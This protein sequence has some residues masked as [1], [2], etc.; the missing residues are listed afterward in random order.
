MIPWNFSKFEEIVSYDRELLKFFGKIP[1]LSKDTIRVSLDF[2]AEISFFS[3]CEFYPPMVI[4]VHRYQCLIIYIC[5]CVAHRNASL[6][7]G[8]RTE[9]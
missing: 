8:K 2:Y 9:P 6:P 7:K 5:L 4:V 3:F 1:R